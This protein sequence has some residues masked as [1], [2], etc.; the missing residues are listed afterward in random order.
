MRVLFEACLLLCV[1]PAFDLLTPRKSGLGRCVG[2]PLFAAEVPDS[3]ERWQAECG[4]L[5]DRQRWYVMDVGVRS[6]WRCISLVLSEDLGVQ[7]MGIA[8]A[9]AGLAVY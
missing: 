3:R 6:N 7:R 4:K 2:V 5:E 8:S 1:T 9:F